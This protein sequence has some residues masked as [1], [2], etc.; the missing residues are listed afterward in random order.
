MRSKT[1]SYTLREVRDGF[2]NTVQVLKHLS[3]DPDGTVRLEGGSIDPVSTFHL[4]TD[5]GF[6][7]FL[8]LV[9]DN[10]KA[11]QARAI[12]KLLNINP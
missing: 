7:Y 9:Q 2:G 12:R 8:Q 3:V 4:D 5:E 11:E 1:F 10:A 6:E